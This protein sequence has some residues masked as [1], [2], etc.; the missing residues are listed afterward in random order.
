M[1]NWI[2]T[3][4]HEQGGATGKASVAPPMMLTAHQHSI[5]PPQRRDHKETTVTTFGPS[6]DT[7]VNNYIRK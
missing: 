7:I 5:T 1:A 6:G 2:R 4:V 3:A